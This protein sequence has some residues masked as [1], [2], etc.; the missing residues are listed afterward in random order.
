VFNE[1]AQ[2]FYAPGDRFAGGIHGEDRRGNPTFF[3]FVTMAIGCVLVQPHAGE[4]VYSSEDIASVAALAKRRAKSEASG[5][6]MIGFEES[7]MLL[8]GRTAATVD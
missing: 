5:F 8:Q 1:G 6:V 2:R 7:Q 3:G 4:A